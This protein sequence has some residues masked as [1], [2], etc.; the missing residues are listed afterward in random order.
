[1]TLTFHPSELRG[2]ARLP[3]SKSDIHRRLICAA[4]CPEG[5]VI[6]SCA[7][8]ED[9]S[10]TLRALESLGARAVWRGED[11]LL[12]G[13]SVFPRM[14]ELHCGES[15]TMLRLLMPVCLARCGGA[16]LVTSGRLADRPLSGYTGCLPDMSV[17][18]DGNRI[19]VRGSLSA[20]H[21]HVDASVSGQFVSGLLTALSCIPGESVLCAGD[22]PVSAGY[23]RMTEQALADAGVSAE[24]LAPFTWHIRGNAAF[25]PFEAT[26]E[27]DCS[28]AALIVCLRALGHEVTADQPEHTYQPDGAISGLLDSSGPYDLS[29]CPDLAPV[30][31]VTL[32]LRPGTHVLTGCG[33]L[34]FK[35]SDRLSGIPAMIRALGGYARADGDTIIIEGTPEYAGGVMPDC[36]GDHRMIMAAALASTRC[37]APVSVQGADRAV[38]SWP[39]FIEEWQALGG[40]IS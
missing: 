19:I 13:P 21:Y 22:A 36:A 33:R 11:L 16:V 27:A 1:M 2:H 38:R 4:L 12:S 9:T 29:S 25:R 26:A 17:T 32:G 39:G 35:E 8:S 5:S 30:L 28:A 20:G 24:R 40:R 10:A 37:R 15:A 6:R 3:R 34:R 23:I 31:A 14:P 7:L 18:R